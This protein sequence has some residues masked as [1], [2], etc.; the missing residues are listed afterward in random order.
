MHNEA[1]VHPKEKL[2]FSVC[3]G[4]SVL[5]YLVLVV[6]IIGILYILF[7]ALIG[8]LVHGLFVGSLRGNGIKVSAQQFPD[9]HQITQ[10]LSREMGMT[11]APDVYI[12][13]AGGALNAFATRFL[14]RDFVVL[15]SDVVELARAQGE[16]ALAFVI[17]HE[18]AHHYRKH[19]SRR[20]LLLPA[21]WFPLLGSAYSR[22]C[23]YTC[24]AFGAH[25]CGKGALDGLLVLAAGKE[26]YREVNVEAFA[27]QSYSEEGFFVWLSE[28]LTTHPHL[29]K[30]V[31]AVAS[32]LRKVQVGAI[33]P[34][35]A[36]HPTP[37]V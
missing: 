18:L 33:A 23:E 1:L 28:K 11:Q 36:G 21:M 27:N 19:T 25:Y 4:I 12:L 7:G 31:A 26:L 15:Y 9:V 17:C 22:A 20:L 5:V 30:R 6:S 32:R 14:G 37:A 16:D 3:L 13:Q 35:P 2:Y 29:P 24:D 34:A 8:L 10:K